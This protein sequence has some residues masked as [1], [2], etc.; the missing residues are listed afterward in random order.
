MEFFDF[1]YQLKQFYGAELYQHLKGWDDSFMGVG[2]F[3]PDYNQFPS[4]CTT[5]FTICIVA[6]VVFYYVINSPRFNRWW[7]WLL[8][9]LIVGISAFGWGYQVVNVDVVSQCIAPSLSPYIGSL[10]AIMF[11]LYNCLLAILVFFILSLAFR[12]WSK[13][14]KHSPW[15]SIVS[16]VNR[17]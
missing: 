8:T 9:L 7:S 2:G 1:F 15:I 6:F 14:C 12:H 10:N 17:K 13:N 3:N 5:T 16:R 11:G 4:I